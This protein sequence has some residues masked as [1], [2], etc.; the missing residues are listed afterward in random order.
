MDDPYDEDAYMAPP[1]DRRYEEPVEI[2][3]IGKCECKVIG[4]IE[5]IYTDLK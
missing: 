2:T 5:D 3:E 4:G 1:F